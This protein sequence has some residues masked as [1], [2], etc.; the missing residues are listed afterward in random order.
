MSVTRAVRP[1]PSENSNSGFAD[2]SWTHCAL[3]RTTKRDINV[4]VQAA[5]VALARIMPTALNAAPASGSPLRIGVDGV[6]CTRTVTVA[7]A[8]LPPVN[9]TV[10]VNVSTPLKPGDGV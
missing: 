7:V 8:A 3:V 4:A 9:A 5:C 2:R 6:G 10:Y 1:A